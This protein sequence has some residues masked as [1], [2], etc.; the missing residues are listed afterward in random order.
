M[1]GTRLKVVKINRL[2]EAPTQVCVPQ[3]GSSWDI[4]AQ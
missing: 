1:I 2:V 3:S 4:K